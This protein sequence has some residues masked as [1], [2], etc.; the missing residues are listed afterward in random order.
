MVPNIQFFLLGGK[1]HFDGKMEETSAAHVHVDTD[2][3]ISTKLGEKRRCVVHGINNRR[4]S[5]AARRIYRGDSAK[6]LSGYSVQI[7][8]ISSKSI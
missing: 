8:Q 2:A 3:R 1:C 5:V 7:S 4:L 6:K